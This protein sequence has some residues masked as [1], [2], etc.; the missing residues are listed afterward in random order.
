MSEQIETFAKALAESRSA[1]L[2]DE[3][4][5]WAG[6][7]AAALSEILTGCD[8]RDTYWRDIQAIAAIA[9]EQSKG[10]KP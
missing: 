7:I 1:R 10:V 3:E 4:A 8:D 5:K 9:Y 2:S 6:Q